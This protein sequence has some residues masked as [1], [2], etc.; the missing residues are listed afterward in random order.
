MPQQ[1]ERLRSHPSTRFLGSAVAFN[2]PALAET[3]RQEPHPA[4][5][6]HRQGTLVHRGPLRL[7]VFTFEP[8]GKLPEHQAPGHV[9]IQ[10]LRGDLSITAGEGHHRL[11]GGEVLLLE[12]NVPHAVEALAESEMLLTVCLH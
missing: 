1:D 3:L 4:T 10:C 2:L 9:I 8:G 6:G 7:L 12:P 5:N 11:R